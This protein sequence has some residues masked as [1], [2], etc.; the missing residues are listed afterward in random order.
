M[1]E[2]NRRRSPWV[3][4]IVVGLAVVVVVNA[5]YVYVAVSGRDPVVASYVTEAR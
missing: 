5:I 3:V 1:S 4:G 2:A